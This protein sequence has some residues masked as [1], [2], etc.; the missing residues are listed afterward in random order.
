MRYVIAWIG[1]EYHCP[2]TNNNTVEFRAVLL[3]V[4]AAQHY[5]IT[6]L[7]DSNLIIPMDLR[8][9]RAEHFRVI[10]QDVIHVVDKTRRV[11]WHHHIRAYSRMDDTAANGVMDH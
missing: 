9:P 2:S 8:F 3:G 4:K 6:D 11:R 1:S 10:Y 7:G 5:Q